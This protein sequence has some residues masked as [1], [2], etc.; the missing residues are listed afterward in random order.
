MDQN[1]QSKRPGSQPGSPDLSDHR[2]RHDS[3]HLSCSFPQTVKEAV[4]IAAGKRGT[5]SKEEDGRKTFRSNM[6]CYLYWL[7]VILILGLISF[8]VWLSIQLARRHSVAMM[9]QNGRSG[10]K[11]PFTFEDIFNSSFQPKDFNVQWIRGKDGYVH[12]SLDESLVYFDI[13]SNSSVKL[14]DKTVFEEL[15]T[16]SYS[17]S[18]D[19]KYIL[20]RHDI[21]KKWRHSFTARYS[22]Y[23]RFSSLVNRR[24]LEFP[25]DLELEMRLSD[26]RSSFLQYAA[27]SPTTSALVFAFG[28]NLFYQTDPKSPAK[29]LTF[30]GNEKKIYNGVADWLYEEEILSS[31]VAHWWSPDSRYLC[32]ASFNDTLVPV[33]RF[34]H[35]GQKSDLYEEFVEFPYP[36]AGELRPDVNP[37]VEMFV[38][39]TDNIDGRHKSLLAPPELIKM[40]HYVVQVGWRDNSNVAVVWSNRAQNKTITT[41]YNVVTDGNFNNFYQ[42]VA[43]GW[44]EPLPQL[45]FVESGTSYVTILPRP[46]ADGGTWNHVAVVTA[47]DN[48]EG[49]TIFL[50]RGLHEV[51]EIVGYEEERH[52]VYYLTTNGDPKKRHLFRLPTDAPLTEPTCLTCNLSDDCQYVS[53][54]FGSGGR[55]YILGCLGPGIPNYRLKDTDGLID[56]MLEDNFE[57]TRVLAFKILPES[58]FVEVPIGGGQRGWAEILT[59]PGVNNDEKTKKHP[60]LV[61][62][63]NSPGSQRVTE[64][65]QLGWETYLVT[66]EEVVVASLDGRGTAS[67]GNKFKHLLYRKMAVVDVEDQLLGGLFFKSLEYVDPA[68]AAIWGWSYGGFLTAHAVANETDIFPCGISGAALTDRRYYDTA[69]SERYMGFAT[70]GDNQEGYEKTDVMKKIEYFRNKRYLMVHGTAD[71]NVHFASSAHLVKALTDA[72]IQ[73]RF[74][75]YTDLNHNFVGSN[76]HMYRLFTDFLKNDCFSYYWR[77]ETQTWIVDKSQKKDKFRIKQFCV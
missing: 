3:G 19:L 10:E 72:D 23:E 33:F 6:L 25:N 66:S 48:E 55:Y 5:G 44:L 20:L 4:A 39:D 16:D 62:A 24:L 47:K 64:K 49:K 76:R 31:N 34:P 14:M 8:T 57:L 52:L 27:W 68:K 1:S 77:H 46:E 59:P 30:T 9:A 50:S 61:Y 71:D 69:H 13:A 11:E 42:T 22:I 43:G 26:D 53:A 65:F 35:Y 51:K 37:K 75:L 21:K 29:Q 18:P 12:R 63:Y 56:D 28:N 40:D 2:S 70:P 54:S 17:V 32:Y 73:F 15:K 36:K 67:R 7:L 74:Q 41:I 38:V 45:L 58:S 60:L